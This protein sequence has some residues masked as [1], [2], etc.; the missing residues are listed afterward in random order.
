MLAYIMFQGLNSGELTGELS[1]K[2]SDLLFILLDHIGM[3]VLYLLGN[4]TVLDAA[5]STLQLL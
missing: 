5:E 2:L 1:T 4:F 3:L